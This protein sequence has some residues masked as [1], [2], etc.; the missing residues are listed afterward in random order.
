MRNWYRDGFYAGLTIFLV[1]ATFLMWLWQSDRQVA[2]HSQNLLHA[3]E[4]EDWTRATEFIGSDYQD[5][6]HN[7]RALLLARIREVFRYL[8]NVQFTA[9]LPTVQTD[10]GNAH[11]QSRI[12]INGDGGEAM[13]VVKE[14]VNSLTA[15]FDLEWRQ[16]SGKPWDWKLVRI[17]HP[18][19]SIPESAE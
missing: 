2:R 11:W 17:G 9:S 16:M 15:P 8:R 6:W 3:I 13:M 1:V 10:H 14:R 7:D 19:L 5:Q 18:E 4:R 12:T